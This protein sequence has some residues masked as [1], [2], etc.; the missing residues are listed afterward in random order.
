[1]TYKLNINYSDNYTNGSIRVDNK[2]WD[3]LNSINVEKGNHTIHI[4]I[5]L[6][7]KQISQSPVSNLSKIYP[8]RR[9]TDKTLF[10]DIFSWNNH[11]N[12]VDF[13][14]NITIND[15]TDIFINFEKNS[16]I[17][18][19]G[20]SDFYYDIHIHSKEQEIE[21]IK[22]NSF[23]CENKKRLL[24]Y[25]KINKKLLIFQMLFRILLLTALFLIP[26]FYNIVDLEFLGL[27]FVVLIAICIAFILRIRQL[28]QYI[29]GI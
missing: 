21:V 14:F 1:M 26:T 2:D 22:S 5:D 27:Y 13:S 19:L 28:N 9:Y 23:I 11:L 12:F 15:N 24:L 4:M 7:N 29:F 20:T 16:C 25:K 3:N 6:S 10:M 8:F 18:Y 17:N